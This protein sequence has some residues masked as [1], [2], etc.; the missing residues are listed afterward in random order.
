MFNRSGIT[1]LVSISGSHVTMVAAMGGAS[2][3]WFWRRLRWRGAGLAERCP[4]QVV[5]ALAALLIAWLY[6]L[7]AGWG[8]PAR[9]TF[10]MLALVALAYVIRLPVS[11]FR[12][13]CLAAGVVVALDPWALLASGYW[14]SFGAVMVLL[15]SARWAGDAVGLRRPSRLRR[16]GRL[17]WNAARLQCTVSLALLPVLAMLFHEVSIVS[18]L[19]NA[20][21]IPVIGLAVTPVTLLA[22]ACAIAPGMGPLAAGLTWL[23]HALLQAMM[24]P[25]VWL[26]D[27]PVA[28]LPVAAGPWWLTL[29]ALGG[30][31]FAA[32][33]YGMP[34]RWTGWLLLLPALLWR[35]ERPQPGDWTLHA[36]DVGQAGAIVVRTAQHTLLFDTGARRGAHGDDGNRIIVPYL[37]A[38]GIPALDALVVSHAD[39]DHA[40]GLLSV[41]HALPVARTYSSFDLAGHLRKEASR[42]RVQPY[43]WLRDEGTGAHGHGGPAREPLPVLPAE[44]LSCVRGMR[45][46]A[47]G[48]TFEFLWP[49]PAASAMSGR[50]AGTTRNE[51]SCVLRIQGARHS[52]LLTGDIGARQEAALVRAGLGH[53]DVVIAPHHGSSK[54][55]SVQFVQATRPAHV[56]A[57]AG[58]WNR[59]G[60]PGMEVMTRWQQAGAAFWRSDWHGAITVES[61][62]GALTVR[63]ERQAARRYWTTVAG[64]G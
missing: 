49:D 24:A 34:L 8:V 21:A 37:R 2:V 13:L 56:I 23:G 11:S 47:D 40:G 7:L 59:H 53:N 51:N 42:A 1:H 33:P 6:C 17:L 39:G 32:L 18:P 27:L 55:S 10:L 9:R 52:A 15:A 25:T 54:S 31:A 36:L 28:S 38:Q 22:A 64:G 19:A 20:Y 48:V 43:G 29:L 44:M 12:V 3:F 4:A 62:D 58:P 50:K 30:V 26:A 45:W 16:L 35:P 14:L 57:Q 41:L 63:S 46:E 5:A 61:R 60:H